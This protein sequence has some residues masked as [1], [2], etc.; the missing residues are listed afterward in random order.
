MRF[1]KQE[2][3]YPSCRQNDLGKGGRRG[4]EKATKKMN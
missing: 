3:K 1:G 2:E 4:E